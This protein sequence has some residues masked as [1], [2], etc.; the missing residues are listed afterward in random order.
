MTYE[1]FLKKEIILKTILDL[2]QHVEEEESMWGRVLETP[3]LYYPR[4]ELIEAELLDRMDANHVTSPVDFSYLLK[5]AIEVLKAQG[6]LKENKEYDWLEL[7]QLGLAIANGEDMT[8]YEKEAISIS[9]RAL[10]ISKW[11]S[12]VTIMISLAALA[13]AIFLKHTS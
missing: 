4:P 7:T 6:Y 11:S 9:N 1:H 12:I 5:K 3:K 10:T 2:A 13:V 8:P